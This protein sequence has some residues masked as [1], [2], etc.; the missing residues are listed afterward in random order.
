MNLQKTATLYLVGS[1]ALL[2]GCGKYSPEQGAGELWI[3]ERG[4]A[5]CV[6]VDSLS[7]RASRWNVYTLEDGTGHE[8]PGPFEYYAGKHCAS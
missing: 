5:R 6:N 4:K 7:L 1:I 3:Y 8:I 2:A